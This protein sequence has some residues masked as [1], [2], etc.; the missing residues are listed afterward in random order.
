MDNT[1]RMPN[2]NAADLIAHAEDARVRT[3]GALAG[4]WFPMI[5]FGALTFISAAVVWRYGE[6]RSPCSGP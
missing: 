4:L 5:L 3:R 2:G 1:E 6:K